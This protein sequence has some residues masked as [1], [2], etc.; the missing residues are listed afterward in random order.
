VASSQ[1]QAAD[2]PDVMAIQQLVAQVV[3]KTI[4]DY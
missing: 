1:K 4:G 2:V 3:N